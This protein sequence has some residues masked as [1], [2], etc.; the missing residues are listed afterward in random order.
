MGLLYIHIY[1][2]VLPL[3]EAGHTASHLNPRLSTLGQQDPSEVLADC[4]ELMS[5]M[6]FIESE[7]SFIPDDCSR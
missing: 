4:L 3:L 5:A 1:T 2:S 6:V 7:L